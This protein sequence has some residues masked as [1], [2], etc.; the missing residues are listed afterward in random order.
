MYKERWRSK[1]LIFSLHI[2]LVSYKKYHQYVC[3]YHNKR[4]EQNPFYS[5]SLLLSFV[6][7]NLYTKGKKCYFRRN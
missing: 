7:K 3:K 4:S 1:T 5:F 2:S 6:A